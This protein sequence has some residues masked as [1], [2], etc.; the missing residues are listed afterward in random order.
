M[1]LRLGSDLRRAVTED[2][3]ELHLPEERLL[4][5]I[6]RRCAGLGLGI[7]LREERDAL[8]LGGTE[9]VRPERRAGARVHI[10]EASQKPRPLVVRRD[11]KS[12]RLNSSH[13][14]ISYAVFC[15]K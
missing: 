5:G 2:R 15:L 10:R 1:E 13:R 12:T 6:G 9:E 14:T 8:R 11:R 7:E 3:E 4:P